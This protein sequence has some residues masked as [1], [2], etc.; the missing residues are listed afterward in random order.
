MREQ[1]PIWMNTL[2]PDTTIPQFS[3]EAI[4]FMAI[5]IT[6]GMAINLHINPIHRVTPRCWQ[7]IC[8]RVSGNPITSSHLPSGRDEKGIQKRA[9][10]NCQ[11]AGTPPTLWHPSDFAAYYRL[12]FESW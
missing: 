8:W 7:F 11:G 1:G 12:S 10:H 2:H 4:G 6:K 5:I 9:N 3:I